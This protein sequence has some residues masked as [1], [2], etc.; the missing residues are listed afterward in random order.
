VK[1]DVL[2]QIQILDYGKEINESKRTAGFGHLL[3]GSPVGAMQKRRRQCFAGIT[4]I[5][6]KARFHRFFSIL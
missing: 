3:N 4:G 1:S 6:R 2:R 5:G